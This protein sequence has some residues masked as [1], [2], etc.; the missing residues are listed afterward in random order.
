MRRGYIAWSLSVGK[1]WVAIR[2][3]PFLLDFGWTMT[4]MH[5]FWFTKSGL[6]HRSRYQKDSP[7]LKARP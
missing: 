4:W 2:L 1:F 3:K 5:T 7:Y 6:H